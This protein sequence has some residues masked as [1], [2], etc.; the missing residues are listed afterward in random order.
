MQC[1][2][3]ERAAAL[4]RD[5]PALAGA[6]DDEG[7]PIVFHLNPES[8]RVGEMIRVLVEHGVD[9]HALDRDGLT[10]LERAQSRGLHEFV[11]LLRASVPPPQKA[12]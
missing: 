9:V 2:T 8:R 11:Q 3:I 1:A 10:L 7:R 4:L 12:P 5:D 6:R